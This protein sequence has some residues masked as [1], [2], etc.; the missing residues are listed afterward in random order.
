MFNY[1]SKSDIKVVENNT[2][3]VKIVENNTQDVKVI[4]MSEVSPDTSYLQKS[5]L[6]KQNFRMLYINE[7][8]YYPSYFQ[9]STMP[10]VI[11]I[12]QSEHITL[13]NTL[14]LSETLPNTQGNENTS[15]QIYN[16][17]T[18]SSNS[19][20]ILTTTPIQDS[21]VERDIQSPISD[22]NISNIEESSSISNTDLNSTI[23]EL[24]KE[25]S[26]KEL[27]Y[28]SLI[29]QSETTIMELLEI[30][31]TNTFQINNENAYKQ[32]TLITVNDIK[33]EVI[34][35]FNYYEAMGLE[36]KKIK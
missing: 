2:L 13:T 26:V 22:T 7:L 20:V 17:G 21:P 36:I 11:D 8:Y 24:L 29:E 3:D 28:K 25:I 15:L 19:S 5:S 4:S 23:A 12:K 1:D 27:E 35:Q 34:R 32:N 9:N 31:K 10:N 6:F 14:P 30:N 33:P 18:V 16:A